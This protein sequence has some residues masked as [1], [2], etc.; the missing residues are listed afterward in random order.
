MYQRRKLSSVLIAAMIV[1][2]AACGSASKTMSTEDRGSE[3]VASESPGST[4]ATGEVSVDEADDTDAPSTGELEVT[5][6]GFA[7]LPAASE[8]QEPY[9]TAVAIVQ[10]PTDLVARDV[11][12]QLTLLGADGRVLKT[13]TGSISAL[14]PGATVAVSMVEDG[15]QD[16]E[17]VQAQIRP[18]SWETPENELGRLDVGDLDIRTVEYG[19]A[20]VNGVVS[21]SVGQDLE[22]IELSVVFRNE[23]GRPIAG[24]FHY[25]DFVPA[26]GESPF[27]VTTIR[28][29][30]DDWSAEGYAT[31]SWM[32]LI[33]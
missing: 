7:N 33:D 15:I 10:N 28:D 8:Y 16:A 9:A 4:E 24:T 29:I 32:T 26:N 2:V 1:A 19:G 6:T 22:D 18:G 12:T 17:D 30:P 11:K 25:V 27:T 14:L 3:V 20:D 5:E 21:S 23:D 13:D 31:P